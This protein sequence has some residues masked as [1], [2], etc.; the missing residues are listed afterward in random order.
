MVLGTYAQCWDVVDNVLCPAAIDTTLDPC[1]LVYRGLILGCVDYYRNS[2]VPV[3]SKV[4]C[5]GNHAVTVQNA[6]TIPLHHQKWNVVSSGANR[7]A[8]PY[9]VTWCR[10]TCRCRTHPVDPHHGDRARE[11]AP[12]TCNQR[13]DGNLCFVR[14]PAHLGLQCCP[15][16]SLEHSEINE[17]LKQLT[18]TILQEARVSWDLASDNPGLVPHLK[19][20]VGIQQ[21]F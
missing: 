12:T 9:I 8:L 2:L 14:R 16:V 21:V 10:D 4:L 1:S 7:L 17:A 19:V 20:F 3:S 6:R 11:L 18:V 5:L 15:Q 13:S